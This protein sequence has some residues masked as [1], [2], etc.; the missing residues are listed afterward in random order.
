MLIM[1]YHDDTYPKF[2]LNNTDFGTQFLR[3]SASSAENGSSNNN[4]DGSCA[5]AL[6]IAT[7]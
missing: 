3:N 2:S 4:N 1:R 6:A 5:K 7:R